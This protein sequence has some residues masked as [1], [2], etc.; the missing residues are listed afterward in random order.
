MLTFE[1]LTDGQ[2][3]AFIAVKIRLEGN[4]T[5]QRHITIN[6]PAGTGK[7]TLTRFIID[8][9]IKSGTSGIMLAAPT[10][11]AKKVLASLAGMP[12]HTIHSILKINPTTYEDEV[13]FTQ[14]GD[15]PDL[16]E[17]NV[18]FCDESSMYDKKLFK[19][20]IDTVPRNCMIVALGDIAQ[21]RPVS[22]GST[23]P[24][25]SLFFSNENFEQISLSEVKRSNGPII[26]VATDIRKGEM[27]YDYRDS[28]TNEGVHNLYNSQSSIAAFFEKYFSI[29]KTPE[30]LFENRMLAFQ[31]KSVDR[32]N[33]IIRK[34]IY[35]T[36]EPFIV[37]EIIVM[38]E[39]L[40][41]T[42]TFG[43]KKF[44]E[45]VF[46]NGELVKIKTV[47]QVNK[48]VSLTGVKDPVTIAAWELLLES[49]EGD[50]EPR[51]G[52]I[53]VIEDEKQLNMFNR[54]MTRAATEFKSMKARGQRPA[55]SQWWSTK[56]KFTRVK[57]LPCGTIHKSQGTSVDNVFLYTP[58]LLGTEKTLSQQLMYVGVTRARHNVYYI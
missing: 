9:L 21:L 34:R 22:P 43:G 25:T 38:Q 58:C 29:V 33:K 54:Y 32:L 13:E 3:A 24:E 50:D 35:N 18:L 14:S 57:P 48:F 1:D 44:T 55:W 39:P 10:H 40:T 6:G 5:K 46:N 26:K 41:V 15:L 56:N 4:D 12:A 37:N 51:E 47:K 17:C 53:T 16:S 45:T 30:D 49:T 28:D 19:I 42:Q 11:Q 23:V 27:I 20:L 7:T 52:L 8:D 2:K 31:N 36:D